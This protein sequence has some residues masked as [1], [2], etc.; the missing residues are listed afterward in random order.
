MKIKAAEIAIGPD[1]LSYS[2]RTSD[3]GAPLYAFSIHRPGTREQMRLLFDGAAPNREMQTL[4]D[5]FND[6]QDAITKAKKE[7][8]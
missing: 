3:G 8:A 7:G 1:L 4:V 6:L 5:A 2:F